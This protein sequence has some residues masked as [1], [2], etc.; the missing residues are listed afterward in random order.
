[1]AA[2]Y[3]RLHKLR[4]VKVIRAD[5]A[6]LQ[7]VDYNA[8]CIEK[9]V[10]EHVSTPWGW[11]GYSQGCANAFRAE[12]MMLQGTPHQQA[13]M[14]TFRCRQLL[15]SA[16][17]GSAHATCGDWKLLRALIDGERFLK[18]FQASMSAATQGLALD[19]L[20]NL[21]SSRIAY[22]VLGSVQSLTHEGARRMWRDGQHCHRAPTTSIRAI[23]EPHTLP[24]CLI[25]L[26]NVLNQQMDYSKHHDTQVAVEEAV[27][28]PTSIRNANSELLLL[29]TREFTQQLS[30]IVLQALLSKAW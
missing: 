27:A 23:T 29:G 18:R 14:E 19:M 28:H 10:R 6:T 11:V 24:E 26:L 1:M 20:Q 13:L 5:T 7:S 8:T 4:G 15:F 22:A 17:N 12:A 21:M 16:A 3:E 30:F 2:T 25:M 9:A